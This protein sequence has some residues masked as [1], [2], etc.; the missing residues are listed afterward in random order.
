MTLMGVGW[1][2]EMRSETGVICVEEI[3]RD[4]KEG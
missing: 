3:I 1:V 4:E 2:G